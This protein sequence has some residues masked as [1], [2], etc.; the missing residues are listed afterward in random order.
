[1]SFKSYNGILRKFGRQ[2]VLPVSK[3]KAVL[4]KEIFN[5]KNT[6]GICVDFGA[7]T[8]FW[9]EWL[10]HYVSKMYAVD[11][12]YDREEKDGIICVN[13]IGY[14]RGGGSCLGKKIFFA[15][16]VFH[17]LDKQFEHTLLQKVVREFD[18][19][20]IKDIDCRKK[21][22]NLMNRLHDRIINGETIRNI[23]PDSLMNDLTKTGYQCQIF[24][25]RKLWY[26]HFMIIARKKEKNE[27]TKT[28]V[29]H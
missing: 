22:G 20:I 6:I 2:A 15:T 1:M 25:M 5:S 14:I 8:L 29:K 16:D 26:P 10:K 21:F 9:A 4:E 17:H 12:I 7:G 18:C 24:M 13:N 11:I 23:N 19:I 27:S 3:I 28:P